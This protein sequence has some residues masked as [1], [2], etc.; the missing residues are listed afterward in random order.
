[1]KKAVE[2]KLTDEEQVELTSLINSQKVER[3]LSERAKIII[4]SS[5]GKE[6]KRIARLLKTREARISKWRNRFY[7]MRMNGLYDGC[8]SGR[9]MIYNESTESRILQAINKQPPEG[10]SVWSGGLLAKHLGD[11]SRDHVWRVLRKN[12]ISLQRKHSWCVSTDPEFSVKAAD[13]V[14]LYLNPPEN[15]IVISVDEKP[16]IQALERAQGWLKLPNGKAITGFNHEYKRHGT[17]TLFAAL[18]IA[19][20]LVK[21]KQYKRR[22]RLEFLDFMNEV[23]NDYKGKEIHVVLDNLRTHKP[24]HDKWITRHKNVHF[25]YTPTHA[26][27]LNMIEI[28]F[29]IL[30]RQGLKNKSFAA[31]SE[32]KHSI[33]RFEEAYNA[34]ASPFEWKKKV[35]FQ[36]QLKLKYAN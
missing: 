16:A 10:Y 12:K 22:R 20:G 1:M 29:S 33:E 2:I 34:D 9:P 6:N 13:I 8:R 27:W 3:R 32:L 14:G 5:K 26:S 11:V 18:E 7:K 31:V 24:K 28:W 30:T 23:V 19:T 21:T 17:I 4:L 35:V 36:K 15:A 25:H